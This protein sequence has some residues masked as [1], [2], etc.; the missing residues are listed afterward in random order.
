MNAVSKLTASLL[1]LT[2]LIL[3]TII[4]GYLPGQADF[5]A[6]KLYTLSHGSRMLL[7][8]I[9]E[10][11]TLEFYF[12]R[13]SEAVPIYYKNYATRIKELLRQ[14]VRAADGRIELNVIDPKNDTREEESAMRAGLSGQPLPNGDT[15]FFGLIVFQADQEETIPMFSMQREPF[16]EYDISRAIHTVQQLV[17]PRLGVI[18]SLPV[19]GAQ[20]PN[21]FNPGQP[22]AQDWVFIQELRKSFEVE[23]IEMTVDE[24]P[25]GI[26]LLAVIHPQNLA[27]PALFA[28]DQFLLS[29]KPVFIAVDP[30]SFIQKSQAPQ[31]AMMMGM[32]PP[33][34]SSH[35]SRLF[36]RWGILYDPTLFVG[37][38]QYASMVGQGGGTQPTRYPA[39]LTLDAPNAES[40]PTANLHNILLPETGSFQLKPESSLEL[41]P[42][43]TSSENSSLLETSLLIFNSP[44]DIA[45][46]ILPDGE[47]FTM[48]GIIRGRFSTAFPEGKPKTTDD[49]ETTG[50]EDEADTVETQQPSESTPHLQESDGPATLI[51]IAD[52]DF[53]ADQFSVE[54]INFL[55]LNTVRPLNDNLAFITNMLEFLAG[56]EDLLSLRGRGRT[57]RPFEVVR[58]LE[59]K[60]QQRFQEEYDEVNRK[61]GDI[62]ESLRELQ[63]RQGDQRLLVAGPEMTQAI[64]NFQE[65]EAKFLAQRREIRKK[66]REDIENLN[67]TLALLNLTIVPALIGLFG[68][69]F[70]IRRNKRF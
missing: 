46:Q 11:I 30:S 66:L 67:N 7:E 19:I 18:S 34:S 68:I 1:L 3:A 16:L 70:F 43:L 57:L 8:K 39:W 59:I 44:E 54:K 33:A 45:R 14:Y 13:T 31:Q 25:D 56:S 28:I 32:P 35:L 5:T 48:A 63:T 20:Q 27:E 61:L 58:D 37:D 10:P 9:E 2:G 26:D 51:I 64:N 40:P 60:A 29:G 55:G 47:K 21:F 4:A 52:T 23:K 53:L 69:W 42:L 6:N 17:L 41:T 49:D 50:E 24:I 65:Q 22:Q 38:L 36:D 62:Q 15:M 12:R